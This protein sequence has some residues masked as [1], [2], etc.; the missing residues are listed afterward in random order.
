M[1][2]V[3]DATA[4]ATERYAQDEKDPDIA[5]SAQ[6]SRPR[7]DVAIPPVWQAVSMTRR[8]YSNIMAADALPWKRKSTVESLFSREKRGDLEL[9][10]LMRA[11]FER[12]AIRLTKKRTSRRPVEAKIDTPG[13]S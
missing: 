10:I 2:T 9:A 7:H 5:A 1:C 12:R 6:Y 4:V 3:V 11:L 13:T 8:A